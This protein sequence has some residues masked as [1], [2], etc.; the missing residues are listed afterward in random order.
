M[1]RR[2]PL[3]LARSLARDLGFSGAEWFW[4]L[5]VPVVAGLLAYGATWAAAHRRLREAA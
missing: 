4:P 3:A 1:K 5:V 2:S